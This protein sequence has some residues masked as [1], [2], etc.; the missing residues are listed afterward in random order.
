VLCRRRFDR[1]PCGPLKYLAQS[2][3]ELGAPVTI[4]FNSDGSLGTGRRNQKWAGRLAKEDTGPFYARNLSTLAGVEGT[5]DTGPSAQSCRGRL[6]RQVVLSIYLSRS[7]CST[8]IRRR[9]ST[10]LV[11]SPRNSSAV[12]P[13]NRLMVR[14]ST[15]L[16]S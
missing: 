14:T 9:L 8:T 16:P 3:P 6:V 5:V 13:A 7:G 15:R 12:L 1:C 10:C 2:A 4:F 11:S